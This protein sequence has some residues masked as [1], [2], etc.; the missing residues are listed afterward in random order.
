MIVVLRPELTWRDRGGAAK[1]LRPSRDRPAASRLDESGAD[2]S[3]SP[4]RLSESGAGPSRP[5][6]RVDESGTDPS[7][8]PTR[9]D[10]SG[11]DP[12]R[13]PTRW[14]TAG[15]AWGAKPESRCF[16]ECS[17]GLVGLT[18]RPLRTGAY[19]FWGTVVAETGWQGCAPRGQP[20][21]R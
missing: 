16:A 3:R 19:Q 10:E 20:R 21:R 13:S 5:P 9:L 12:S 1:G 4:T 18:T 11:T 8:P 15:H 2:P 6:T 14:G 17:L 7:R